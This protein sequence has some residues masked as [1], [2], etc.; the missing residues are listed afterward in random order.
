M[1]VR[2]IL[3]IVAHVFD[4]VKK[5]ANAPGGFDGTTRDR[6]KDTEVTATIPVVMGR[7]G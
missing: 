2:F 6:R 1:Y 7:K 3:F 5:I 4:A